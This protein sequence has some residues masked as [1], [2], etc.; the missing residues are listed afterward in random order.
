[1]EFTLV[2]KFGALIL[3]DVPQALMYF[4]KTLD[5]MLKAFVS[6]ITKH[7]HPLG[8]RILQ[9]VHSDTKWPSSPVFDSKD[10]SEQDVNDEYRSLMSL[11][12][13]RKRLEYD[14]SR[15]QASQS[16]SSGKQSDETPLETDNQKTSRPDSPIDKSEENMS[17]TDEELANV[18]EGDTSQSSASGSEDESSSSNS[19]SSEEESD[20]E[21]D[22]RSKASPEHAARRSTPDSEVEDN[23]RTSR[24]RDTSA[25]KKSSSTKIVVEKKEE[26]S[27]SKPASTTT[28]KSSDK[29]KVKSSTPSSKKSK[30]KVS[31]RGSDDEEEPGNRTSSQHFKNLSEK[32]SEP[33]KKEKLDAYT[34][35]KLKTETGVSK[36]PDSSMLEDIGSV[37][38]WFYKESTISSVSL[39]D[40]TNIECLIVNTL[41]NFFRILLFS[42]RLEQ[43]CW[44]SMTRKRVTMPRLFVCSLRTKTRDIPD[45]LTKL[46]RVIAYTYLL[47]CTKRQYSTSSTALRV[48]WELQIGLEKSIWRRRRNRRTTTLRMH[49]YAYGFVGGWPKL[50]QTW[51]NSWFSCPTCRI[52]RL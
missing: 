6:D 47:E 26:K 46:V 10:S 16:G 44:R 43:P 32:K 5:N 52:P 14:N 30:E 36:R 22:S 28:N 37:S 50:C 48:R 40:E 25:G 19:S 18:S 29:T 45:E 3:G 23:K 11:S 1:M 27:A 9:V 2:G 34:I 42:E 41:L 51:T 15:P 31:S 33:S 4:G 21:A 35:P 39:Y 13:W 49:L 12:Y 38:E 20:D 8:Y 7:N 24:K 17:G